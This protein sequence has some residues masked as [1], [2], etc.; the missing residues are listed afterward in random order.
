MVTAI[1]ETSHLELSSEPPRGPSLTPRKCHSE[2]TL[3]HN[4]VLQCPHCPMFSLSCVFVFSSALAVPSVLC[5][6]ASLSHV[7]A[8]PQCPQCP[9][10]T[11]Q[12]PS[13]P[14]SVLT[15]HCPC[16]PVFLLFTHYP[17][18]PIFTVPRILTVQSVL[19]HPIESSLSP[20]SL[21]SCVP[22]YPTVS[23]LFGFSSAFLLE[24]L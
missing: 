1:R 7:F 6:V 5:P 23:L 24:L 4:T 16:C 20:V 14:H 22:H 9:V 21:L 12:C 10:F 15:P 19:C 11:P 2:H 17:H 13:C 18:C 3:S 8:A